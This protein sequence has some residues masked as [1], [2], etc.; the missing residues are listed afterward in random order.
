MK[1]QR[2]CGVE[3]GECGKQEIQAGKVFNVKCD[4]EF[5]RYVI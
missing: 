3:T 4:L 1:T 5:E 2:S